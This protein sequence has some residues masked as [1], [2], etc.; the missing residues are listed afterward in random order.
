MFQMSLY[1]LCIDLAALPNEQRKQIQSWIQ[2]LYSI[3]C[4]HND[5]SKAKSVDNRKWKVII[6]GTRAD[7]QQSTPEERL[8]STTAYQVRF[9]SIPLVDVIFHVSTLDKPASVDSLIAEINSQCTTLLNR[10]AKIPSSYKELLREVTAMESPNHII[11][12]SSIQDSAHGKRWKENPGLMMRALRHLHA[13]GQIVLFGDQM[14]CAKPSEISKLMAKFISPV[15][16][17]DS[18]LLSDDDRVNLLTKTDINCIL[19]INTRCV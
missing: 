8:E 18:L 9:P 19:G 1:V 11:T 3:L 12:I 5:N 7:L 17:R 13:I 6:V 2:Y 16:V 4:N 10:H 14:I 15:K